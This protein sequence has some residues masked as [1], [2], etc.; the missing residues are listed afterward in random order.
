MMQQQETPKHLNENKF[1]CEIHSDCQLV[2]ILLEEK[3]TRKSRLLCS[4][5]MIDMIVNQEKVLRLVY[6]QDVM[7]NP[8]NSLLKATKIHESECKVVENEGLYDIEKLLIQFEESV[9]NQL[10]LIRENLQQMRQQVESITSELSKNLKLNDLVKQIE[11]VRNMDSYQGTNELAQLEEQLN[12]ISANLIKT[13]VEAKQKV[14]DNQKQINSNFEKNFI[15]IKNEIDQVSK[16]SLKLLDKM[17]QFGIPMTIFD[18]IYQYTQIHYQIS[19]GKQIQYQLLYQGTRDGLNAQQYWS[20]C[21]G[22]SNLLTIMTSKNGLKFGG[23]SPCSTNTQTNSYVSDATMKSFLQSN[24]LYFNPR[25]NFWRRIRS[26]YWLTFNSGSSSALGTNYDISNYK[27]VN[28]ATHIFGEKTPQLQE[29]KVYKV[30][31]K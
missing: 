2:S 10:I 12:Q 21:N 23:Y 5:C 27:I 11:L 26:N 13:Y 7:I 14:K 9:K 3:I 24:L 19:E 25:T 17:V 28:K 20:K 18:D 30:I 15:I 16:T 4:K 29:C 31:F 6:L 1:Y 8:E 22:Q